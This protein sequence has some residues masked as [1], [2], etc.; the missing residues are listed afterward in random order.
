MLN[1]LA[2]VLNS[3]VKNL[4]KNQA[5]VLLHTSATTMT[6]W[7]LGHHL[8]NEI[9]KYIFWLNDDV[10]VSKRNYDNRRPDIIFHKRGIF[11]LDF[12]VV[13]VKRNK[14]DDRSDIGKIKN[15]WMK[16]R[17][18]YNYGAYINIWNKDNYV[19]YVFDQQD[20]MKD[21]RDG[22]YI[23]ISSV[24]DLKY[25]QINNMVIEVKEFE[26]NSNENINIETELQEKVNSIETMWKDIIEENIEN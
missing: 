2:N 21:I 6:E 22:K 11:D 9:K 4:F 18:N 13:E 8:S 5:D 25:N 14:N 24:S 19:G 17:L 20:N 7:N 16:G 12:L 1:I 10:D 3:S 23:N 26:N 15:Y